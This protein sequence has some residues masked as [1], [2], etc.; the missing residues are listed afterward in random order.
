MKIVLK[1]IFCFYF[2]TRVIK[3]NYCFMVLRIEKK[4]STH[5]KFFVL[6]QNFQSERIFLRLRWLA[7]FSASLSLTRLHCPPRKL[8]YWRR[9]RQSW[10]LRSQSC[11]RR[12]NAWSL[13]SSPISRAARSLTRR[14][15]SR[16]QR[17]LRHHPPL[18]QWWV[19]LWRRTR[20]TCLHLTRPTTTTTTSSTTTSSSSSQRSSSSKGWCRR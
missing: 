16:H 12:R 13:S 19:W 5:S 18:W 8:T 4:R 17:L 7:C 2:W 9:R 11:R 14:S 6:F 20:S 10:R 1:A 15:S 3:F